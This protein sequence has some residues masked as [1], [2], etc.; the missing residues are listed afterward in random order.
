LYSGI[1]DL[2]VAEAVTAAFLLLL[3]DRVALPQHPALFYA[4]D[5]AIG[6]R[7]NTLKVPHVGLMGH[8]LATST[9]DG[10]AVANTALSD[11]S[12]TIAVGKYS[13]SYEASDLARMAAGNVINPELLAA[14]AMATSALTL[15]NILANLV[16]N[17][18]STVGTTTVDAT[19][20]NF[21]DAITTLEVAK[22]AGPYMA[23]LHPVQWG[24]IRKDLALNAG[25]AIQFAPATAE[26]IATRGIGY[27]GQLAGVDV[28][29]STYVPTANS[30]A[31]R[32]GGMFGR[33]ALLWADGSIPADPDLP[34]MSIGAK[35]LFE[36]DRTPKAG[37]TAYVMHVYLGAS[38]GIDACGVSIITDA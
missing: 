10:S 28:F 29:T 4:G 18:S 15:T 26:L 14:D 27:Q 1:G 11:G 32:A 31:D 6:A 35:V 37:L 3:A 9:A 2:V 8:D 12:T 16:D 13:K 36:K 20:A 38:E 33:G 7:S 30:G 21:L 22:V 25:G 23:V 5:I 34:Q 24:D 17:F 19:A